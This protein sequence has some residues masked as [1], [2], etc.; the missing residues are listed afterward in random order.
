MAPIQSRV[1]DFVG[2]KP[3][4]ILD[5]IGTTQEFKKDWESRLFWSK[6]GIL[7]GFA[8]RCLAIDKG[9]I[10]MLLYGYSPERE[11]FNI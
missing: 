1:L 8:V 9:G 5:K 7:T 2:T 4:R 3:S 10:D 11:F 6:R